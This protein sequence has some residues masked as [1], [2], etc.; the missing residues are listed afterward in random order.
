MVDLRIPSGLFFVAPGLILTV[1]GV[2]SPGTRPALTDVNVNLYS[3]L[4]MVVFG[5]ILLLLSRRKHD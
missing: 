2:A 1:L 5:G 4:A 3:G